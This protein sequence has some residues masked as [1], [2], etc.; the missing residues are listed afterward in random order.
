MTE[1]NEP[2][3]ILHWKQR[4]FTIWIGQA[5]SM[6]GSS[7]VGFA[8]VWF[9]TE[10]TGSAT[11]LAVGSMM[12]MLPSIIIGPLAGAFVDRWSRKAVLII[13]DSITALFTFL[14]AFLFITDS[15]QIWH[16]YVVM[17]I[18]SSSGQFQLA[19]M[20]ASTSLMVPRKQLSRV[21]GALT[22]LVSLLTLPNPSIRKMGEEPEKANAQPA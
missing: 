10:K 1:Q 19:A 8:F 17:F 2:T 13:S 5:F 7:L 9:L 6:V 3:E 12:S 18:R 16:I 4:F 22:A 11:V 21:A 20:T 14:L 15:A